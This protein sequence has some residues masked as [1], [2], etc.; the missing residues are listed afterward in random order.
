MPGLQDDK[1]FPIDDDE[2]IVEGEIVEGNF[3]PIEPT[4][5]EAELL[6]TAT[7]N[8]VN[9]GLE[10]KEALQEFNSVLTPDEVKKISTVYYWA[11]ELQQLFA[12]QAAKAGL[13]LI[14]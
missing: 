3:R 13:G 5:E 11:N 10:L 8:L 14:P 1:L 9:A 2:N 4:P 12:V 6:G 7:M